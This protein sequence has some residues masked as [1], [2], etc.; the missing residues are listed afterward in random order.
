MK[1]LLI[2]HSAFILATF[3][4]QLLAFDPQVTLVNVESSRGARRVLAASNPFDFVLLDLQIP[5][6]DGFALLEEL[7]RAYPDTRTVVFSAWGSNAEVARAVH[8]GAVA[9]VPRRPSGETLLVALRTVASGGI[10]VPPM[11][12]GTEA[13]V[14]PIMRRSCRTAAE[15]TGRDGPTLPSSRE[16]FAELR[17][18]PRQNEVLT[19]LLQGHSNKAMARA[20]KLS[21]ETI[22]DHVT[23]LL[24][25]LNV[26]S[27]TQVVLA[28]NG[29][30][31][32]KP[33]MVVAL[34]NGIRMPP[35][36]SSSDHIAAIRNSQIQ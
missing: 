22:K 32:V 10:Y 29:M 26:G 12:V 14:A 28:V 34:P 15:P 24:R 2:D 8:L 3:E 25:L 30:T 5:G 7:C 36:T 11:L 21:V 18:T 9:L 19:L 23:A 16:C 27:R 6:E 20:L 35:R 31:R 1:A 33:N 4:A 13:I 17:L